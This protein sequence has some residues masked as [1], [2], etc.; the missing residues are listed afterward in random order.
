MP[1][2]S[3]ILCTSLE[4]VPVRGAI[5]IRDEAEYD[6]FAAS[7]VSE[8]GH[9]PRRSAHLAEGPFDHVGGAHFLRMSFGHEEELQ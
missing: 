2:A 6:S 1:L 9:R 5:Q 8:A 4:R 7:L 3:S